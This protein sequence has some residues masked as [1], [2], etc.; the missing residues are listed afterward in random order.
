MRME[1][2][3]IP[4]STTT[5]TF[6][7]LDSN[8]TTGIAMMKKCISQARKKDCTRHCNKVNW[9]EYQLS[10]EITEQINI[11]FILQHSAV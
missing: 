11:T 7:R 10:W 1:T 5:P 2:S 8:I 4:T 9:L 6:G 3:N